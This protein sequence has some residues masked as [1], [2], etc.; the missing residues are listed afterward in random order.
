VVEVHFHIGSVVLDHKDAQASINQAVS[1]EKDKRAIEPDIWSVHAVVAGHV[2][3]LLVARESTNQAHDAD[4]HC[5]GNT[6]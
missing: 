5:V 3:A 1:R 2:S 6:K 4:H